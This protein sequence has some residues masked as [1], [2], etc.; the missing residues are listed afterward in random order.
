MEDIVQ[1]VREAAPPLDSTDQAAALREAKRLYRL[2]RC[3]EAIAAARSVSAQAEE[4]PEAELLVVRCLTDQG[5]FNEAASVCRVLIASPSPAGEWW[6]EAG[7]R[8]AWLELFLTGD[9]EAIFR[10][11]RSA[12]ETKPEATESRRTLAWAQILLGCS[13][14]VAVEWRLAPAREMEQARSLAA[15]SAQGFR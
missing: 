7:L 8:L 4:S 6:R 9:P 13:I 5:R 3:A 10:E 15:A 12:L 2:G 1:I 14:A 11:G